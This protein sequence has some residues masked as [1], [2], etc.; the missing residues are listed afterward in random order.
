MNLGLRVRANA[1]VRVAYETPPPLGGCC[2]SWGRLSSPSLQRAAARVAGIRSW[3]CELDSL[4]LHEV[5]EHSQLMLQGTW[6]QLAWLAHRSAVK[7]FGLQ[8]IGQHLMGT[9]LQTPQVVMEFALEA[10]IPEDEMMGRVEVT[11][12]ELCAA[13][14]HLGD[15]TKK[16]SACF[17]HVDAQNQE[18]NCLR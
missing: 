6:C 5:P 3:P 14:P 11:L 16:R 7:T 12:R 9:W 13:V 18:C 15:D 10:D 2:G 17:T 8:T 4:C 1:E